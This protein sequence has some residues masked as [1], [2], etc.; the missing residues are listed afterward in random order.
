MAT[1]DDQNTFRVFIRLL[2]VAQFALALIAAGALGLILMLYRDMAA[3][4]AHPVSGAEL[5]A[6]DSYRPAFAG[7][8]ILSVLALVGGLVS[9]VCIW[10]RRA[11]GFSRLVAVLA[12]LLFPIGTAIGLATLVVL[13]QKPIRELYKA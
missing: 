6:L 4:A 3:R 10:R 1:P 13:G 5:H 12:L 11:L 8:A 7:L 9:G 2:S